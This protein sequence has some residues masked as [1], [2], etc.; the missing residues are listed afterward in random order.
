MFSRLSSSASIRQAEEGGRK[1]LDTKQIIGARISRLRASKGL[2]QEE[3][4]ERMG[5][6]PKYL[7]SIERGKENPTLQT[8]IKAS[9]SLEI[10]FSEMLSILEAEDPVKSRELLHFMI[11]Q[12]D[13][14]QL[15]IIYSV[16]RGVVG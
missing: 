2:T 1:D 7:S 10:D 16:I 12:A 4:A 9:E 14:E 8:L 6:N 3:L 15:R 13:E 11:D 5:I